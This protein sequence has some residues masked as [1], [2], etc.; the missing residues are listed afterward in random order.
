MMFAIMI[1]RAC[2]YD[3]RFL[4]RLRQYGLL[5]VHCYTALE[6]LEAGQVLD[7]T[8]TRAQKIALFKRSVV[9]S[10]SMCLLPFCLSGAPLQ[11][12]PHIAT[13]DWRQHDPCKDDQARP[14]CYI[15]GVD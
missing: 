11:N 12:A 8:S 14:M 9:L 15:P 4:N 7:P 2:G 1:Q 10:C 13:N 6:R 3:D 5:D